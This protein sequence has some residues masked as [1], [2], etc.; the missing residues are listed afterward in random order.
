MRC[1]TDKSSAWKRLFRRRHRKYVSFVNQLAGRVDRQDETI[2]SLQETNRVLQ[3]HS[4]SLENKVDSQREELEYQNGEIKYLKKKMENQKEQL[5]YQNGEINYLNY[6]TM[7]LRNSLVEEKAGRQVAKDE[8]QAMERK[9]A[10]ACNETKEVKLDKAKME[11]VFSKIISDNKSELRRTLLTKV[12]EAAGKRCLEC[13]SPAIAAICSK[14]YYY[15]SPTS[16]VD[17]SS[18]AV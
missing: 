17:S 11:T 8:L 1:Y 18:S 12:S 15:T 2:E 14:C 5:E 16:S 3:I 6:V 4:T 13:A 9:H 7:K 10:K